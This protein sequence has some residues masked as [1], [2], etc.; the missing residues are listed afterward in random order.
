M[1]IDS[2]DDVAALNDVRSP[3]EGRFGRGFVAGLEQVRYVVRALVP[4]RN[5]ALG[6]FGGVGDRGQRL[7]IDVD[8]LGG[9]LCL[10]Q[11]LGH[12]K[13]DR[14]ADVAHSALREA[15][16]SAS[17]HRRSV[18]PFA[19]ERHAHD[20]ELGLDEV[21]ASHAQRNAR[22][23]LSC[24]QLEFANAGMGVRRAQHVGVRLTEQ[25][26]IALEPAVAAEEAL[27]LE[28]PHWLP[29]SKL[30]HYLTFPYT[31]WRDGN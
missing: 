23:G 19:L 13:C 18:R 27:I 10:R 29:D 8:Q 11:G 17:E 7:V 28:T 3:G 16:M 14:L 1:R 21:V 20:A 30:A 4:H 12:D 31:R 2:A 15:K 9:I 25:V 26:V 6:R 5:L 22:R 24:R